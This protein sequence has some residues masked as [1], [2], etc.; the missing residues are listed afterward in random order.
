[1]QNFIFQLR[2]TL[3]NIRKA[4]RFRIVLAARSYFSGSIFFIRNRFRSAFRLSVQDLSGEIARH[5]LYLN[6]HAHS[7]VCVRPAV[8][9]SLADS[10]KEAF[11]I[12]S[13][14]GVT[15]SNPDFRYSILSFLNKEFLQNGI[16][17]KMNRTEP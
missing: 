15:L 2:R 7:S 12:K 16:R 6:Q 8:C 4:D 5:L 3:P 14:V 13:C 10:L 1:M 9:S 11:C 17:Y